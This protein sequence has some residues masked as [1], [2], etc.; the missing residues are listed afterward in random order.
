MLKSI[1]LILI[2]LTTSVYSKDNTMSNFPYSK[3]YKGFV[4]AQQPNGRW[5][6]VVFPNRGKYGN[7]N[8]DF[9]TFNQA[10]HQIDIL[11][12]QDFGQN[13]DSNNMKW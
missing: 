4:V 1:P 2:L 12:G 3:A 13:L 8:N 7:I 11:M 10:T 9:S 5:Q 6:I